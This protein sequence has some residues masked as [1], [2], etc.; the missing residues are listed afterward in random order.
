MAIFLERISF[1]ALQDF[2]GNFGKYIEK[3]DMLVLLLFL[4]NLENNLWK[5]NGKD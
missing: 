1:I 5:R 4:Q 2:F 3:S